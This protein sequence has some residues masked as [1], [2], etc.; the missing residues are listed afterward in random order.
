M[1]RFG[2]LAMPRAGLALALL[3]SNLAGGIEEVV[4][5]GDLKESSKQV[6]TVAEPVGRKKRSDS[7]AA[8]CF[9][10]AALTLPALRPKAEAVFLIR[11]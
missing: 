5:G 1:I 6:R 4:Q 2:F 3:E 10:V 7:F 11:R 8:L 9:G